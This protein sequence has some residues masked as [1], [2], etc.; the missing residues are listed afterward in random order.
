MN[1][2][3]AMTQINAALN[4]Y[5]RGETSELRA[6]HRIA[7]ISGMNAYDHAEAAKDQK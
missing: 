4:E 7:V 6:L 2:H 1:D 3:D 5:F